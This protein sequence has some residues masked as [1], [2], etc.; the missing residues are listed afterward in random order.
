MFSNQS[1]IY[2]IAQTSIKTKTDATKEGRRW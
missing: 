1:I 2:G